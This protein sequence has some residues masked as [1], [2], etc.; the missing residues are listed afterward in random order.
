V[1]K[2]AKQTYIRYSI[3]GMNSQKD[4]DTLYSALEEIQKNTD[5]FQG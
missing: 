2:Q 4:L 1:M 3:N 5:F